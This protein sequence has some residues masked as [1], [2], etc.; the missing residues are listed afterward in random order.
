MAL[1]S[2]SA[3]SSSFRIFIA[4]LTDEL[5]VSDLRKLKFLLKDNLPAGV[6]E[7]IKDAYMFMDTL[8]HKE[9]I[10]RNNL[11]FLKQSFILIG[12]NDLERQ[13]NEFLK[14]DQLG[15]PDKSVNVQKNNRELHQSCNNQSKLTVNYG[16]PDSYDIHTIGEKTSECEMIS[17][18]ERNLSDER[19][20]NLIPSRNPKSQTTQLRLMK[21]GEFLPSKSNHMQPSENSLEISI[22]ETRPKYSQSYYALNSNPVGICHI[23]SNSFNEIVESEDKKILLKRTGTQK[24]VIELVKIFCWL[25]F[26]I[27]LHYDKDAQSILD[28]IKNPPL[29]EENVDCFVC[30][31]LSHG[32]QDGVYG[33]DGKK[34]EFSDMQAAIRGSS[35]KWLIGK[36]K[37]FFIQACQGNDNENEVLIADSPTSNDQGHKTSDDSKSLADNA[38]FCFSVAAN[39]GTVS[40]RNTKDGSWYIQALCEIL[41]ENAVNESL[42]N[43]LTVLNA[44]LCSKAGELS[45]TTA[46]QISTIRIMTLTK[47]LRFKPFGTFR[48]QAFE[49]RDLL[50]QVEQYFNSLKLD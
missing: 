1:A 19:N 28:I 10:T 5:T 16:L 46:K 48:E 42:L 27:D 22:Q 4:K 41:K 7:K 25:N 13:I 17:P 40:W 21:P 20:K 8:E 31:I 45:G 29:N 49:S 39:P 3:I 44:R 33:A 35:A 37:I 36:P 23:I 6:I 12:R 9:L 30:C 24:D 47:L 38:D 11:T 15:Q 2:D 14:N 43:M 18:V 32:F 26:K 50:S 34:L